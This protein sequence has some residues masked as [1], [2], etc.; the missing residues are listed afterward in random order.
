VFSDYIAIPKEEK[1]INFCIS[2]GRH[3]YGSL[4]YVLHF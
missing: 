2:S 1:I 4:I 3:I